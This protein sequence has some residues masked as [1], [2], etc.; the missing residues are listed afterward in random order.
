MEGRRDE[1]EN[2]KTNN[3]E[4]SGIREKWIRDS[5]FDYTKEDEK[6]WK[7]EKRMTNFH[8]RKSSLITWQQFHSQFNSWITYNMINFYW[9]VF[10]K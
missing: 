5:G 4:K 1:K 3:D 9:Y 10:R 8:P 6:K 7:R 2:G